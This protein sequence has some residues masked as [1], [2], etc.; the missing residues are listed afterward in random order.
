[1]AKSKF[2]KDSPERQEK[3]ERE[4]KK[5]KRIVV[6]QSIEKK[7]VQGNTKEYTKKSGILKKKIANGNSKNLTKK[8]K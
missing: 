6:K 8:V 5:K 7:S 4:I 2:Y 1:M 3:M